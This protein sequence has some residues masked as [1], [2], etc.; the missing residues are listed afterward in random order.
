[1][2]VV[3]VAKNDRATLRAL[4]AQMRRI[5]LVCKL[6]GPLFIALVNSVSTEVAILVSFALNLLS[7]IA[8]YY[9]IARVYRHVPDLQR[10]KEAQRGA[11]ATVHGE[12]SCESRGALAIAGR[13][14][15]AMAVKSTE[16]FTLYFHHRVFLP[17]FAGALLYLTVLSFAGQMVTYLVSVG[18]NTMH[19]G[20]A[21][22]ASVVL[23]VLATWVA[24]WLMDRVGPIRAGLWLSN[25][26]VS[27][28]A[29]GVA[30]FWAFSES[31]ATISA[32]GLV[33]GTIFSR[34]GLRGFD[35]CVQL[36]IQEVKFFPLLPGF[37]FFFW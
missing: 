6:L 14:I 21:R 17:S 25:W 18:Y 32:A 2:Q 30:V 28:L 22:T 13:R 34:V 11:G 16:D 26:Q 19:I 5:D 37:P 9:A 36:I 24:P 35:L 20:L 4:N 12:T 7:V 29:A 8:E 15:R 31:N 10:P 23:E 27:M 1:M 33:L 3:V